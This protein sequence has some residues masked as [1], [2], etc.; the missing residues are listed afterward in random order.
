VKESYTQAPHYFPTIAFHIEATSL[1]DGMYKLIQ[2]SEGN[3]YEAQ[4]NVMELTEVSN[5]DSEE[6]KP[7]D[8][9]DTI[10]GKPRCIILLFFLNYATY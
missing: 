3:I 6:S 10:E 7:T 4:V 9:I 1:A 2:E 8:S 5:L